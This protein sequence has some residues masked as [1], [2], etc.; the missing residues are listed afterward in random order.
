MKWTIG[1]ARILHA[2]V[3]LVLLSDCLAQNAGT[4]TV[5]V[6]LVGVHVFIAAVDH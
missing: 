3:L 6:M 5:S 4:R 1:F 2:V